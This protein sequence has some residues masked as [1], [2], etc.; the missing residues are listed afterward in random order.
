VDIKIGPDGAMYVADF[1]NRII[2]HYEVP[3]DHPGRDR[4][5]GRIWKITYKGQKREVKD[6]TSATEEELIQGMGHEVLQLRM[7]ATDELVDRMGEISISRL[8][9]E[10]NRERTSPEQYIQLQ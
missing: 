1:Y 8:L 3:L 5:S 4:I 6:W 2:G 7:M 10:I 9:T